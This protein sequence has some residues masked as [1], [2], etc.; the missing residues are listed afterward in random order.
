MLSLPI[1]GFDHRLLHEMCKQ[2]PKYPKL[3]QNEQEEPENRPPDRGHGVLPDLKSE[4]LK[5]RSAK[6]LS[7]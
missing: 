7:C 1:T 5:R 4:M 6:D 2:L 3:P